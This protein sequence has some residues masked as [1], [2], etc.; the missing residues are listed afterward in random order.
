MRSGDDGS[1]IVDGST[2]KVESTNVT[3]G[4]LVRELALNGG[5]ASDNLVVLQAVEIS[6]EIK[7]K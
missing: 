6:P 2:T 7:K 3:E 5:I 1:L 4:N